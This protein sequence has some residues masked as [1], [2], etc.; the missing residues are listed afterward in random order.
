M[1]FFDTPLLNGY[2]KLRPVNDVDEVLLPCRP[3]KHNLY[4]TISEIP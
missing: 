4:L 1:K 2:F 3:K